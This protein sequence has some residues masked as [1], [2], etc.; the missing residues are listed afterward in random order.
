MDIYLGDNIKKRRKAKGLT[1]EE[2]AN[3]I[4]V[5]FQTVSKWERGDSYPDITMLPIL[6]DYFETSV[7]D[8][9]GVDTAKRE[10]RA[11]KY[12]SMYDE[13]GIKDG[14]IVLAE[15]EK[16][17]KNFP[18]DHRI[19][20]R[21][22]ALLLKERQTPE[23]TAFEKA[24]KQIESI[25]GKIQNNCIDD[26]VRIWAKR[27]M[28]KHLLYRYDCFG[29]DE[30][31]RDRALEIIG[32]MPSL[33]DSKEYLSMVCSDSAGWNLNHENTIEEL[34]YLLQNAMIGYCLSSDNFAPQ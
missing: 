17:V 30:K 20:V 16:A 2:F 28:I 12:I 3:I 13:M 34:L 10:Q 11:N 4:G 22:M 33:S 14:E 7:D 26:G 25:Y 31:Y 32:T 1:Q 15:F 24:S 5:A 8:L 9:L 29:Y 21:Y 23:K 19:S 27:L 18:N 6:A